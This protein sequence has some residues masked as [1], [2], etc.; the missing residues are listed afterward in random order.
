MQA[1][2]LCEGLRA[3]ARHAD[4]DRLRAVSGHLADLTAP[5]NLLRAPQQFRPLGE[6]RR[7]LATE[8]SDAA[9]CQKSEG[10]RKCVTCA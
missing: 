1:A 8:Y 7:H 2:I 3:V 10:K 9:I 4:A 5:D 6:V